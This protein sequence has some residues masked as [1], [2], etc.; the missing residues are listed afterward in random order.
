MDEEPSQRTQ[1]R[2]D[3]EPVEIPVPSR[4][5]FFGDLRKV[6]APELEDSGDDADG[7][8]EQR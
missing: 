4:E 6:S 8:A 5:R 1:P 7:A 2:T 3:A